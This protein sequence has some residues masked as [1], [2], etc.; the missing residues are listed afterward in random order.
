MFQ[1]QNKTVGTVSR[2]ARKWYQCSRLG[3]SSAGRQKLGHTESS[4]GTPKG[5]SGTGSRHRR[6]GSTSEARSQAQTICRS[7]QN[8]D[9]KVQT[10]RAQ[11]IALAKQSGQFSRAPCGI[12]TWWLQSHI[13]T[14]AGAVYPPRRN[15][16]RIIS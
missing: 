9:K 1:N 6:V 8:S 11:L 7:T 5:T 10:Q 2:S 12:L 4:F 14:K 16:V 3:G 15:I 13:N